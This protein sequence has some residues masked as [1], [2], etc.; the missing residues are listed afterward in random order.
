MRDARVAALTLLGAGPA[1][2]HVLAL[3]AAGPAAVARGGLQVVDGVAAP[4]DE[5]ETDAV[6]GL[7]RDGGLVRGGVGLGL[8][9]GWRRCIVVE[10]VV[11]VVIVRDG[12]LVGDGEREDCGAE[13]ERLSDCCATSETVRRRDRDETCLR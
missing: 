7:V 3:H 2:D 8:G 13:M 5:G 9:L 6:V 11:E 10:V 1:A 12:T 4:V